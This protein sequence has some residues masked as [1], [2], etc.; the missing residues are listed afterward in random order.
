GPPAVFQEPSTFGRRAALH[1]S[2][3]IPPRVSP[4]C[5]W[6]IVRLESRPGVLSRRQAVRVSAALTIG[7]ATPLLRTTGI[8][9]QHGPERFSPDLLLGAIPDA[10]LISVRRIWDIVHWAAL[11]EFLRQE[12]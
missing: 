7:H 12:T 1:W 2:S 11:K 9:F 10:S 3:G 6:P 8:P 5:H 4:R